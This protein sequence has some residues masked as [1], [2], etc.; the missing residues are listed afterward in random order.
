MLVRG[1]L[2]LNKYKYKYCIG[3]VLEI[4]EIQKYVYIDQSCVNYVCVYIFVCAYYLI[5]FLCIYL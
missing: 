4:R 1:I 3:I 2:I 5:I